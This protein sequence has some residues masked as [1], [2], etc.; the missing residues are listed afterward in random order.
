MVFQLGN[1]TEKAQLKDLGV[2]EIIILKCIF[3]NR[4]RWCTGFIWLRTKEVPGCC[5]YSDDFSFN[6][7][8]GTS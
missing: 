2:D 8:R 7:I 5:E 6:K 4:K 1:V 3:K